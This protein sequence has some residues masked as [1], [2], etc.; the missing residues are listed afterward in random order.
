MTGALRR[1][2][3]IR[4]CEARCAGGCWP[5]MGHGLRRRCGW[6]SR[7]PSR[8]AERPG[9]SMRSGGRR[10]W[11]RA[12]A[13]RGRDR[14]ACGAGGDCWRV[15][16]GCTGCCVPGQAT[17][18]REGGEVGGGH[19]GWTRAVGVACAG[20]GPVVRRPGLFP[21]QELARTGWSTR[22]RLSLHM[23]LAE[24]KRR[25]LPIDGKTI[26]RASCKYCRGEVIERTS[27]FRLVGCA[28]EITG[29]RLRCSWR[30][31]L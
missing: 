7:G 8:V 5:S 25:P 11:T 3:A 18:A 28:S 21:R 9:G 4:F 15:S 10:G 23:L 2:F 31:W 27:R 6:V 13:Q 20:K 17:T 19:G 16:A 14:A 29:G 24:G 30:Q 12:G 26:W 1:F 22:A